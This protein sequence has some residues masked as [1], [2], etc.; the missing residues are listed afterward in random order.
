MKDLLQTHK[1]LNLNNYDH[2]DVQELNNW[3]NAAWCEIDSLRGR[4]QF[5]NRRLS[6]INDLAE[7]V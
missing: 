5:A 1:E 2:D 3:A 4:L 6:K 7:E